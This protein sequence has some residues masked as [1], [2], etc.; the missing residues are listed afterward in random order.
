MEFGLQPPKDIIDLC[1]V[2]LN[3]VDQ[4]MRSYICVGTSAFSGLFGCVE[5]M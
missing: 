4:H 1:G 2:L 5:M 3:Q